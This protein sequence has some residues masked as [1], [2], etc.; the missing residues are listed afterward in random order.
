MWLIPTRRQWRRWSMPSKAGYLGFILAVV[1]AIIQQAQS[2]ESSRHDATT[3]ESLARMEA[4][5]GHLAQQIPKR[6]LDELKVRFPLGFVLFYASGE[7][8]IYEPVDP[9]FD[10][11]WG[12]TRLSQLTPKF[13]QLQLPDFRVGTH[14]ITRNVGG[15]RR[16]PGAAEGFVKVGDVGFV[17]QYVGDSADGALVA[18]GAL[19]DRRTPRP[20]RNPYHRD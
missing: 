17:V 5:I 2:C 12:Q 7:R 4:T 9:K 11:N 8:L 14:S 10:A 15:V 20:R 6:T 16:K 19:V 13:V 1:F 18:F 3:S